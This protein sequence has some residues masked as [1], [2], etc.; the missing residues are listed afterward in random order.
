VSTYPYVVAVVVDPQF[1]EKLRS[2]AGRM[3]VW[4]VDSPTNEAVARSI[5]REHPERTHLDG[6]TTYRFDS[7][8]NPEDWCRNIIGTVDLHHG[9]RS[10]DPPYSAIEVYGTDPTDML[11]EAF[12]AVGLTIC[13]PFEGGFRVSAPALRS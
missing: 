4:V 9:R 7:S 8:G 5:S 13:A 12:A 6:I 10:H 3:P 11:R 2:L 1:G